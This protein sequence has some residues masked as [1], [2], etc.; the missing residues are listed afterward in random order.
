MIKGATVKELGRQVRELATSVR[1]TIN[2]ENLQPEDFTAIAHKYD[3]GFQWDDLGENNPGCYLRDQAKIVLNVRVQTPER[4]NFTFFHELMHNRIEATVDLLSAI[5]DAITSKS[6]DDLIESLCEIGAAEIM[7]PSNDVQQMMTDHGFSTGLIPVLSEK[8]KASSIAVAIQMVTCAS[9]DCYFVIAINRFVDQ[10][11]QQMSLSGIVLPGKKRPR[12]YI[13][14][15]G[16]SSVSKYP[17]ARNIP[18]PDR[19]LMY[20]ALERE[21][22]VIKGHADIPRRN[23]QWKPW[24]VDC[25]TL[26]FKGKVFA[27]FNVD[28]PTASNQLRLF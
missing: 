22:E 4:L 6:I 15:S 23:S 17:M 8:Y 5:H 12:L 25:E 3:L 13:A 24:I 28:S 21:G 16:G 1:T 26:C 18:I 11:E 7:M 14:Y 9:H 10:D 27:F 2:A 20:T 19:H